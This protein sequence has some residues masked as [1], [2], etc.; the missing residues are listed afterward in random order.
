M[1]TK[2]YETKK[3]QSKHLSTIEDKRRE[4][5]EAAVQYFEPQDFNGVK[6][7]WSGRVVRAMDRAQG[8]PAEKQ[9]DYR[10]LVNGIIEKAEE[11]NKRQRDTWLAYVEMCNFSAEKVEIIDLPACTCE[12]CRLVEEN[13]KMIANLNP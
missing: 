5:L 6:L 4:A 12:G 3:S 11:A 1:T 9:S 8:V 2:L 13:N 10:A 7:C